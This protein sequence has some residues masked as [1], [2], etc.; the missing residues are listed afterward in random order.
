MSTFFIDNNHIIHGDC[1]ILRFILAR[2]VHL[3]LLLNY[4]KDLTPEEYY[5]SQLNGFQD[6]MVNV[7][8]YVEITTQK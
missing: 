3:Y 6:F 1:L 4:K 8:N 7:Y 2:L 5:L